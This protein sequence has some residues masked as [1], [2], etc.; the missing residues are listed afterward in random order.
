[1]NASEHDAAGLEREFLGYAM[2]QSH[3]MVRDWR[4]GK[5]E[6]DL[7]EA[8]AAG[9]RTIG[10]DA[11]ARRIAEVMHVLGGLPP[12]TR[13]GSLTPAACAASPTSTSPILRAIFPS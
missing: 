1:M 12:A 6:G 13:D 4:G 9:V 7:Q 8:A 3:P 5:L 11:E 10:D 2:A